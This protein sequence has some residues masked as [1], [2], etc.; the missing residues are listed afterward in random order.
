M[1]SVAGWKIAHK[2]FESVISAETCQL[3]LRGTERGCE[4][5]KLVDSPSP[6]G[7]RQADESAQWQTCALLEKRM[8]LR[9]E[10]RAR[11]RRESFPGPDVWWSLPTCVGISVGDHRLFSS[12]C[13]HPFWMAVSIIV[14]LCMAHHYFLGTYNLIFNFMRRMEF[15][16]WTDYIQRLTYIW[17][18]QFRWDLGFLSW[19]DLD[20]IWDLKLQWVKTFG[21]LGMGVMYFTCGMCVNL[22]NPDQGWTV[23]N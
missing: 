23:E 2:V 11:S 9:V 16:C 5:R 14:T 12:F 19:W 13:F 22:W 15:C 7:R 6:T 17:L 3:G 18:G 4:E 21:H 1:L 8:A 10:P 20:E